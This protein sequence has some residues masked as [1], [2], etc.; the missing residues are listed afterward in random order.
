MTPQYSK[1]SPN[2]ELVWFLQ[3]YKVTGSGNQLDMSE[4]NPKITLFCLTAVFVNLLCR[5]MDS[6]LSL[7]KIPESCCSFS[8]HR[9]ILKFPIQSN[10]K[11]SNPLSI[12]SF[13][14]PWAWVCVRLKNLHPEGSWRNTDNLHVVLLHFLPHCLLLASPKLGKRKGE[15]IR[16][17][18]KGISCQP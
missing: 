7:T 5:L 1:N 15:E 4:C 16:R 3:H 17:A 10:I 14:P 8:D 2:H 6:F 11:V 18:R 12:S 13:S 9:K